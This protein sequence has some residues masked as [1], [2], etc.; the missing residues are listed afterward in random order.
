MGDIFV[1]EAEEAS[2]D[3]CDAESD[4]AESDTYGVDLYREAI[5]GCRNAK[6]ARTQL[7]A[8]T[9]NCPVC[10]KFAAYLQHFI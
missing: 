2:S 1:G 8:E 3:Q 4:C 6:K 5:A 10:A 7:R 9:T